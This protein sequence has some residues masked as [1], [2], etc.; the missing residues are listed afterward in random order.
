MIYLLFAR[1]DGDFGDE[2]DLGEDYILH[3]PQDIDEE[4]QNL[5][6]LHQA[7]N[8]TGSTFG[9]HQKFSRGDNVYAMKEEFCMVKE[10]KF[11]CS[12]DILLAVFQARCQTPGCTALP[13]LRYTFVGITFILNCEC[14]SGHKYR[15]CS[16][17]VANEIH[18][19]NLQVA[20]SIILSGSNFAKV[21]RM[22]RFLSLEF[23]S[24]STYYRFQRLYLI[25][26]INE[27]WSWIRGELIRE[28]SGRDVVLGGDGQCDSPGF[29]AKNLCYF[30]ME[31]ESSYI[32][33]VEVVDK[34]HVGQISQNMEKE[35]VQHSL[36][37]LIKEIKL[38]ELVT[39]ASTSVRALLGR[40]K[41]FKK[42][43]N[44]KIFYTSILF[45][46]LESQ[47]KDIV[48]SLDVWHKSKSIKKC[49]AKVCIFFM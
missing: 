21:E 15:F 12:L 19:N 23:L 22:A 43:C 11:I 29:N 24:K 36:N 38:V 46:F 25:P 34:R 35:A 16:S 31:V 14:S 6:D 41:C 39:D 27:W 48:Y 45:Q 13:S 33:D 3:D 32:L 30:M 1:S 18:S 20:A 42:S 4:P 26:E 49:L 44:G 8:I 47:Y 7:E 10:K 40:L 5:D 28:F 17:H 37:R 9:P 2:P